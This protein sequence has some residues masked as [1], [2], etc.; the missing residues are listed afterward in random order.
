MRS[1]AGFSARRYAGPVALGLAA[2]LFGVL[3]MHT[4]LAG[5]CQLPPGA[6]GDLPPTKSGCSRIS[7]TWTPDSGFI[8]VAY[9][10]TRVLS[11]G[12]MVLGAITIA[13]CVIHGALR[14]AHRGPP[15]AGE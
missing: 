2:V 9:I 14:R 7:G 8:F 1:P 4:L 10:A 5:T 15:A 6:T 12:L 11:V 13:A 3:L